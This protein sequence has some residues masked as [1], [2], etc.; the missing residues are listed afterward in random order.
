MA[1]RRIKQQIEKEHKRVLRIMGALPMPIN[2]HLNSTTIAQM[3]ARTER[4]ATITVLSVYE[5]NEKEYD[6]AK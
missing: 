2:A 3:F 6:D 1:D 5:P 4:R